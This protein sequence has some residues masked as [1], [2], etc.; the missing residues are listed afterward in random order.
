MTRAWVVLGNI[1]HLGL[2]EFRS[3]LNDP[4]LMFLILFMFTASVY[5]DATAKPETLNRAAIAIV[6]E[7]QSQ[8]STRMV[9]ALRPPQFEP[10]LIGLAEIDKGMDAGRHTFV[11]DIPPNFARDLLAGKVPA[12]QLNIDATRL[13]QART[14]SGYIAS[15]LSNEISAYTSRVRSDTE[16]PVM[17][18]PRMLFNPNIKESWFA[19]ITSVI[20][21]ITLL[22]I[23]LT[24]AALIRERE[25][26]T[27]E[28]LLVM[29][30]TA[31]EIMLSKI[32]SMAVVVLVVSSLSIQLVVKGWL[33]V[34][35]EGSA[36]LF[37][38][39]TAFYLF[40]ACSMGIFMA[41]IARSMPQFALISILVLLPLEILSGAITPRESMPDLIQLLMSFTPTTHFVAL[42]QAVLFRGESL[43]DVWL[44]FLLLAV[45][46]AAFFLLALVRLKN[47]I[48]SMQ[49]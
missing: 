35:V 43:A 13:T 14:G 48:G 39:G 47:T 10:E 24:G 19:S 15:I 49:S 38:L 8:L 42:A 1:W 17:L 30:V 40:A 18:V 29:P 25:H 37:A 45:I 3:L 16:L 11:L 32:W 5:L 22:A 9:Q 33:E 34:E 36:W 23:L 28:H 46:G 31:L 12:L 26:G 21:N 6:D 41:T 2:K 7:D 20:N 27:I 44:P 4:T